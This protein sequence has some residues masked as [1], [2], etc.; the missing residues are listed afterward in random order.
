MGGPNTNWVSKLLA[1]RY[2][3]LIKPS[4]RKASD[5]NDELLNE[6]VWGKQEETLQHAQADVLEIFDW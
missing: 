1:S 2:S 5:D 4:S 6:I 3:K